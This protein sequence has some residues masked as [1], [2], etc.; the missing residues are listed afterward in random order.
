MGVKTWARKALGITGQGVTAHDAKGDL[1]YPEIEWV[2]GANLNFGPEPD[3]SNINSC[4]NQLVA[5]GLSWQP[6]ILKYTLY[7]YI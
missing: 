3:C 5:A 1:G 6:V 4:K 7:I 2:P